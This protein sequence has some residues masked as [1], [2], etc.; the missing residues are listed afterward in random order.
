VTISVDI[1]GMPEISWGDLWPRSIVIGD[2]YGYVGADVIITISRVFS[3]E[4]DALFSWVDGQDDCDLF[5]IQHLGDGRDLC[6]FTRNW[7]SQTRDQAEME[8]RSHLRALIRKLEAQRPLF[9]GQ[10]NM[11]QTT[12]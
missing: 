4:E 3:R 6:V 2:A 12:R 10:R 9:S 11:A 1:E 8:H 7:R 5:G